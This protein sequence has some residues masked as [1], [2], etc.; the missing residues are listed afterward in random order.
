MNKRGSI[1]DAI[2]VPIFLLVIAVT[3]LISYFVWNSFDTGFTQ[4]ISRSGNS[5]VTYNITT[6][7]MSNV[8]SALRTIDYMYP[9]MFIGLLAVSLLFAYMTGASIIYA[10]VSLFFWAVAMMLSFLFENIFE[11]VSNT[12]NTTT[13]YFPIMSYLMNNAHLVVLAWLL[14][15][16][17]VMFTRSK[18]DDESISASERAF[19]YG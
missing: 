8:G 15:I 17:I 6:Q 4:V 9:L 7:A 16:S 13:P 1:A 3:T 18:K 11:A 2:Y 12:L 14:L 5:S 10:F 19:S